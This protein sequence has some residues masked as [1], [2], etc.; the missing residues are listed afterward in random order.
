MPPASCLRGMNVRVRVVTQHEVAIDIT[1]ARITVI[2]DAFDD[3]APEK[4]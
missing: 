2:H 1:A 4:G 3:D